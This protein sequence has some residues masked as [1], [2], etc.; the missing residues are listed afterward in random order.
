MISRDITCALDEVLLRLDDEAARHLLQVASALAQP[1]DGG[2]NAE[3]GLMRPSFRRVFESR[4]K[5]HHATHSKALDRVAFEDTFRAAAIADGRSVRG[6]GSATEPFI[7]E[8]IDGEGVA[9]K[10]TAAKDV[11]SSFVHISKLSE[12]AWIQDVRNAA[13]RE[14][15]TKGLVRDFLD[16]AQRVYQLRVLPDLQ[17]WQYQI[18]EIPTPLFRPILDLERT[19]FAADG[20]RIDVMDDGGLC[21]RLV[22]DRS[23]AKITITRIPIERC[24][25]HAEWSLPKAHLDQS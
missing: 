14:Q 10:S 19:N 25:V 11:R 24:V 15:R 12:A 8:V 7:D 23:D 21:L 17:R 3:Q 5:I 2:V 6:S 1:L 18:V 20:P 22:L 4:I 9:L 13:A 16:R